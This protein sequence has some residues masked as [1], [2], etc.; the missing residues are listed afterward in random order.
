MFKSIQKTL[1]VIFLTIGQNIQME[2]Y[3]FYSKVR[4]E[5][6]V[7]SALRLRLLRLSL[8]TS[9]EPRVERWKFG[10]IVCNLELGKAEPCNY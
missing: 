7:E 3:N 6:K 2:S 8:S 9:Q 1:N 5:M 4:N 10:Q